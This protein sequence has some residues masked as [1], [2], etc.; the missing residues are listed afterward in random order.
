MNKSNIRNLALCVGVPLAVVVGANAVTWAGTIKTWASGD[1]L[2]A[3]D[4]NAAFAEAN[5][6]PNVVVATSST[7]MTTGTP[8]VWLDIPGMSVTITTSGNPVML[9]VNTDYNPTNSVTSTGSGNWGVFTLTRDGV[10][11][12]TA[13]GISVV[14][15]ADSQNIPVNFAFVDK[16]AAAGTHVYKVQVKKGDPNNPGSYIINEVAQ[17]NE[18]SA[19]ELR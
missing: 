19:Y 10:N 15:A 1:T 12:G 4:L 17:A 13:S 11:L 6:A 14:S 7:V 16:N 3:A 18:L 5:R 2:T 9:T 8:S